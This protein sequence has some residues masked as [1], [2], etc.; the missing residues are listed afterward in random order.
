MSNPA[1]VPDEPDPLAALRLQIQQQARQLEMVA[2]AV[3]EMETVL[4]DLPAATAAAQPEP[5]PTEGPAAEPALF[6]F[7]TLYTWVHIHVATITERKIVKSSGSESGVGV[8]WCTRWYEH[9][10]AIARLEA[11]RRAWEEHVTAP[12]PACPPGTSPTTTPTS[13]PSPPLA[14]PSGNAAPDTTN[15]LVPLGTSCWRTMRPP[16]PRTHVNS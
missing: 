7:A 16:A 5:A 1:Q 8:R 14:A 11:L 13:P 10:E 3:D 15:R 9:D 12:E 6:D 4:R 2:G